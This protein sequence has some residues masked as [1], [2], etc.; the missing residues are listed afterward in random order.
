MPKIRLSLVSYINTLPF[1]EGFK[2]SDF[3]K[4]HVE[5]ILDYPAKCADNILSQKVD[6]GLLPVGAISPEMESKIMT[7]YCIGAD[8]F[9]RTVSL[10]SHQ[11]IEKI[12]TIYLD[13]QSRT[14]VRLCQLIVKKYWKRKMQFKDTKPGFETSIR[15][16]EA[17][18]MIGDR[19]FKYEHLFK[20][21]IDLAE[22]WKQWTGLPFTFAVWVGNDKVRSIEPALN[23][24]FCQGIANIPNLSSD[25]SGID[26]AT[27]THYLSRN[28]SYPFDEKKKESIRLLKKMLNE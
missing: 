2:R 17:L 15:E 3:L 1:I 12:D 24:A 28:I 8:G 11:P 13:Y 10:F 14:S 20:Y 22:T 21:Q 23:E 27:F 4:N 18:V 5:L 7:D 26:Q 9:V 6:G 25:S 16:N 19:V